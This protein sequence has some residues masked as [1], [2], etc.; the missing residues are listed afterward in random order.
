MGYW[1]H[2]KA[3][4]RI[5]L[6][7]LREAGRQLLLAFFHLAHGLVPFRITE[8]AHWGIGEE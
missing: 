6:G 4:F 1:S 3:N 5:A 8:H 2:L 7:S